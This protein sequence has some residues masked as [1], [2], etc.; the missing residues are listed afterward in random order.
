MTNTNAA[1]DWRYLTLAEAQA[2][3]CNRCGDCCGS[4]ATNGYFTWGRLP[5]HQ[6]RGMGGG[7]PLIIPLERT[8]D[9][10]RDRPH[11]PS[12][13]RNTGSTPFRCSAF[14]RDEQGLGG[15]GLHDKRRPDICN[16]FPVRYPEL[17]ARLRT[18]MVV[19]LKTDHFTRCTW[20]GVLLVPD[21]APVLGWRNA[22]GTVTWEAL[23]VEQC[24]VVRLLHGLSP[25]EPDDAG[26]A[27]VT[28]TT[29]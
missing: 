29:P 12:D 25:E 2:L 24:H 5:A 3:E 4:T 27:E 11:Q 14:S 17:A 1:Q 7:A 22:D 13:A 10:W 20:Y 8:V 21:D 18:E 23:T 26:L 16:M 15:C 9:G 19:R 28:I 6:Y